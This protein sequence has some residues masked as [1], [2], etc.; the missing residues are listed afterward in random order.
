MKAK[1]IVLLKSEDL[2][3]I[4]INSLRFRRDYFIR[5]MKEINSYTDMTTKEKESA[6][7]F[8]QYEIDNCNMVLDKMNVD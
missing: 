1:S 2:T 8:H 6:L 5:E 4:I 3:E 7:S